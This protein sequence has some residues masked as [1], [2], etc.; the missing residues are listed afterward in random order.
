MR[1]SRLKLQLLP[2][3]L[4]EEKCSNSISELE[5]SELGISEL[6]IMK[7]VI[8]IA[9]VCAFLIG[10]CARVCAALPGT[11]CATAIP[12]GDNY[13]AQITANKTVWYSAWTF[14]LPLTVYFIP[15]HS[16]DPAPEVEMDF[17][18]L[19]G[20][21]TDSILCSLFCRTGGNSGIDMKMP[22]KPSLSTGHLDDGTFVY[23]LSLGKKYRDLLLQMGISYNL[24][25]FV[26]VTYNSA[27]TI[28]MAPDDMFA[29]CMDGPKFM[30]LGDTVQVKSQDRDRHVIV[31]YVQ[32][33][34]DSIRYVWN[35]TDSV[36]IAVSAECDYDPTDNGDERILDFF[37][38]GA[39]DTLKL[40]ADEIQYYVGSDDISSQAG[41]FF[42]KFYSQSGGVMKVEKIPVPPPGGGATLLQYDKIADIPANNVNALYAFPKSWTTT[43][44]IF[45]MYVS[46]EPDFV[47]SD[48]IATYKFYKTDS[49]H[50]WGL[51]ETEM[52]A[53]WSQ[54]QD[55]YLYIRFEC[56]EKTSIKPT[57]WRPSDC[58]TSAKLITTDVGEIAVNARSST[59]YRLYYNDW[60]GGELTISWNQTALCK[61][62]FSG[63]CAIGT[64]G[65]A[66]SIFYYEEMEDRESYTIPISEIAGWGDYVDENGFIY[67][68]LYTTRSGGGKVTI[69]TTAPEEQDP[70]SVV[71]PSAGIAV[72]CDGEPTAEGQR[73]IVRVKEEQDLAVYSG[74]IHN[75]ASR[76]P[77]TSWHQ[78]ST[79][80]HTITLA[81]GTYVLQGATEQVEITVP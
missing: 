9:C 37:Q 18:C 40:T 56:A 14:D 3:L 32:W 52:T 2:V 77:V 44:H 59:I 50:W 26:K 19:S 70:A 6:E 64:N 74:P 30:H 66:A 39:Q 48:A 21:Y 35:G 49:C 76:T 58:V 60:K 12:L 79:E 7:R 20:F 46:T 31:P 5:I 27:G 8:N 72:V 47:L 57:I 13:S 68:R 28:S 42:A 17:S 67:M 24:E 34:E 81:P 29:N 16:T 78:T 61:L 65:N 45:K 63:T 55:Q 22:H 36:T 10:M 4:S 41:M 73:Y 80:T 51:F 23:Y 75:I 1:L 38:L 15:E 54:T 53:L 11:T 71:Y 25:V 62:L 33:Q 43:D 69:S